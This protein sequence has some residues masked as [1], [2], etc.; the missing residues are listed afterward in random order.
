MNKRFWKRKDVLPHGFQVLGLDFGGNNSH[1]K[2]V[3]YFQKQSAMLLFDSLDN[4]LTLYRF[5]DEAQLKK[6][7]NGDFA[8]TKEK[9]RDGRTGA[10]GEKLVYIKG[11]SINKIINVHYIQNVPRLKKAL[12]EAEKLLNNYE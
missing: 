11:T 7:Q 8:I 4:S 6:F 3:M 5:K 12:K 2:Y 1:Y 9:D 10:V